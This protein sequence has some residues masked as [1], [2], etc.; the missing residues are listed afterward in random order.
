MGFFHHC[1]KVYE[2][3]LCIIIFAKSCN[4]KHFTYFLKILPLIL[5]TLSVFGCL[6][7]H[8]R[9]EILHLPRNGYVRANAQKLKDIAH[10]LNPSVNVYGLN[11]AIVCELHGIGKLQRL[12]MKVHLFNILSNFI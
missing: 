2:L 9:L 11:H 3:H 6:L 8:L 4:Q 10:V 1:V 7:D 12:D 5:H